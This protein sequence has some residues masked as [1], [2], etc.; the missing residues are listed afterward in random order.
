[1][2]TPQWVRFSPIPRTIAEILKDDLAGIFEAFSFRLWVI[3][4]LGFKTHSQVFGDIDAPFIECDDI[5]R[6]LEI[7]RTWKGVAMTFVVEAIWHNITLNLWR[8]KETTVICLYIAREIM[9]YSSDEYKQG[10]WLLKFLLQFTSALK[11]DCCGYGRD[12]DYD[13]I[14][15]PLDPARVLSRL[16][17]G[18]LFHIDSPVIHAIA[19]RL[20]PSNEI[21]D[22]IRKH[23]TR[24]G[25]QYRE[26][27]AGYHVLWNF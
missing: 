14:Y 12:L 11:A 17:D 8:E 4:E 23:G 25:F 10:E 19:T 22:L 7:S 27:T 2:A 9:W 24:P 3:N 5:Q 13:V 26:S 18:S 6:A 1:M 20:I 21:N 15:K 16:R